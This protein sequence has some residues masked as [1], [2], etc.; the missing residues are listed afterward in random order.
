MLRVEVIVDVMVFVDVD[1]G[2]TKEDLNADW[3]G[4]DVL[5]DVLDDVA[6]IVGIIISPLSLLSIR[7][8]VLDGGVDPTAP[9]TNNN[10]SQRITVSI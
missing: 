7:W 10:K 5:V 1:V 3:L 4:A 8:L 6:D 9:I 2:V